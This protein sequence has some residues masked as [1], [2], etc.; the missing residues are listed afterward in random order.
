MDAPLRLLVPVSCIERK[1]SQRLCRL[2]WPIR[3]Q[4]VLQ[5]NSFSVSAGEEGLACDNC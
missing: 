1:G 2:H 5:A 3:L 4:V